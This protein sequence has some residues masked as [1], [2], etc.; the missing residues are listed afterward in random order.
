MLLQKSHPRFRK[1][2]MYFSAPKCN[3]R[4][5]SEAE[6]QARAMQRLQIKKKEERLLEKRIKDMEVKLIS[7]KTSQKDIR[8][9]HSE[10]VQVFF[11]KSCRWQAEKIEN[12]LLQQ[13]EEED[14]ELNKELCAQ[15]MIMSNGM[16]KIWECYDQDFFAKPRNCIH[17]LDKA[18]FKRW[19]EETGYTYIFIQIP[20]SQSLLDNLYWERRAAKELF[21]I[22]KED[23]NQYIN[24]VVLLYHVTIC[25]QEKVPSKD[26]MEKEE[27]ISSSKSDPKPDLSKDGDLYLC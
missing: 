17:R 24:D 26:I 18:Q 16:D 25:E 23:E 13:I 12:D 4:I 9:I 8:K 10:D 14:I 20:P 3:L 1:P 7:S 2:D 15:Q 11:R 27:E 22:S 21:Y 19:A 5:E 6:K